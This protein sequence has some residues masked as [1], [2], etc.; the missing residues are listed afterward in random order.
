[1]HA[2]LSNIQILVSMVAFS[3]R[4]RVIYNIVLGSGVP[5]NDSVT[6]LYIYALYVSLYMCSFQILFPYRLLLSM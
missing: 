2:S 4:S 5:Q 1:M 3:Y 6:H